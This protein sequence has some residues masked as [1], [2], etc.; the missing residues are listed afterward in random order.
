LNSGLESKGVA[1]K[2]AL[3]FPGD[4]LRTDMTDR[5]FFRE[6]V[7]AA[8]VLGFRY[9]A[10]V[11]RAPFPLHRPHT[12]MFDNHPRA[13]RMR[14][15][16]RGYLAVDP[17]MQHGLRSLLPMTWVDRWA[18][19][20]DGYWEDAR[21]HGQRYGWAQSCRDSNGTLGVLMLAREWRPVTAAELRETGPQL[22]WLTQRTHL[23]MSRR[24]MSRLMPDLDIV[25]TGREVDVLR[26]VAEGL[27]APEIARHLRITLRTAKFHI[28]NCCVKLR[29][30]NKTAAAI[31][32][33][34]L[35]LI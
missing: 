27:T 32:A 5:M 12:E 17:V 24:L 8:N 9:C 25:L 13:W 23:E 6:V 31:R 20:P 28:N 3:K 11:I 14:Y 10:Y 2:L 22:S 34:L 18:E 15:Q 16:E 29:A 33:V 35:G 30:R 4:D 21:A 26:L 19:G 1:M 7:R